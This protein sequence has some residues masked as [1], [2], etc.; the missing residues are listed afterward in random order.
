MKIRKSDIGRQVLV[1][2]DDVGR[3][4]GMIIGI[5]E[6]ETPHHFREAKVF[7]FND[8]VIDDVEMSQIVELGE[9]V[10]PK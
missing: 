7:F 2:Y 8:N 9:R 4:E 6:Y 3:L 5:E 10:A 1:K